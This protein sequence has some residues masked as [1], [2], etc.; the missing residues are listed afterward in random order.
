[1]TF[2]FRG[3]GKNKQKDFENLSKLNLIRDTVRVLEHISQKEGFKDDNLILMGHSMGGS[4]ATFTAEEIFKNSSKYTSLYNRLQC[5]IVIDV[6]EGTAM[7]ALPFME[8]VV[9][10]RP[11]HFKDSQSA[12]EYMYQSGTIRYLKSARVSVPTLIKQ[13]EGSFVWITNLLSSKPYWKEWFEGLTKSF[14]SIRTPK[15]LM[16]AGKERMD[17]ELMI[18]QMQG[19]FKMDVIADSGHIMH[20]DSPMEFADKLDKFVKAFRIPEKFSEIKPIV[21]KLGGQ[22]QSI[23]NKYD[24]NYSGS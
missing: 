8:S 16:I 14:L 13:Q 24:E 17:K 15:L 22:S 5:L 18:A 7:E 12:I 6:V 23:P 9:H 2:D 1:M 20:E 4:I 19:K 11:K 10:S 21:A 3:H